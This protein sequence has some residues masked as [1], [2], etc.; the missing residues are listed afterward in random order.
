MTSPKGLGNSGRSLWHSVLKA[1]PEGWELD[2][3]ELALL[4][5]ACRQRDDLAKLEAAIKR[6]G[7]M[8][9]GSKGQPVVHPAIP[10]A[11]QARL[12]IGRL[13]G[14]IALPDEVAERPLTAAGRR[15]RKAAQSRWNYRNGT[16]AGNGA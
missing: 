10:E 12:A 13:L 2:E 7:A 16:E 4:G 9:T 8:T 15:G 5:V 14:E 3:R 11:R 6:D 1:M